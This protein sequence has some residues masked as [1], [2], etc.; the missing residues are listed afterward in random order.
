MTNLNLMAA[1]N[2]PTMSS[3]ELREVINAAR[4]EFSEPVVENSHFIKRVENELDGE[5]GES[6]IF[7]HPQSGAEMKFY[8]LTIEQCTLVG[9][10][11][12]KGVRRQV[13]AKLKE[14]DRPRQ[15][16]KA[17]MTLMVISDLQ[18]EIEQQRALIEQQKPAVDFAKRI[19][20]AEKGVHLG[21][22]AKSVGLGPR[23]IFE[24]L[25]EQRVLM[26]NGARRNLP[27][28]EFVE[29]GYFTVRQSTYET[30]AETRISHTPLVTGKGEQWLTNRL[31][32][33]GVL[34]AVAS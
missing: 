29:R 33:S 1:S 5:L 13:V 10:R 18:N 24:I 16:S 26:S 30:N 12:S 3:L 34:K 7:R 2:E 8:D 14:K 15:L 28:Q 17:E 4:R 20:S 21:N 27:Y 9:M 25:R 6:K 11:E 32:S 22:F 23:K 31:I 19:A